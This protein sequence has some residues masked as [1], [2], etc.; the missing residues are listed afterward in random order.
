M[1]DV[2]FNDMEG[3]INLKKEQTKGV[4]DNEY[5]YIWC[6]LTTTESAL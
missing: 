1:G 2:Y 5:Y 6:D 3:D 4:K